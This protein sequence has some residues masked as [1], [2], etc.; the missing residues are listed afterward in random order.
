[1]NDKPLWMDIYNDDNEWIEILVPRIC[2]KST[3]TA[4]KLIIE[5]WEDKE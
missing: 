2:F 4:N 3:M 5:S 1:M